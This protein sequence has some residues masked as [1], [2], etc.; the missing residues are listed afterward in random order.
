[1]IKIVLQIVKIVENPLS[2]KINN[3]L[4][5]NEKVNK[6][7]LLDATAFFKKSRHFL[8]MTDSGQPIYSRYGN[9]IDNNGIFATFS[10]MISKFTL[11][12]EK[13]N[14]KETLQ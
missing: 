1:M 10:A 2:N 13:N 4:L 12:Q 11:N 7:K 14:K 3:K 9:A 6:N 8:I 5:L